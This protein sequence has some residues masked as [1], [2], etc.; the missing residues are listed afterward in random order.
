VAEKRNIPAVLQGLIQG[1]YVV[2]KDYISRVVEAAT[3][4]TSPGGEGEPK[5]PL[6]KDFD[7]SWPDPMRFVPPVANEPIRRDAKLLAPNTQRADIFYGFTFVF[8]LK[9]Q[10]DQ[11]QPVINAGSGKAVLFEKFQEGKTDPKDFVAFVK[12][13]AGEKGTGE[14]NDSSQNKGVVV[15]RLATKNVAWDTHFVQES[16]RQLNQRSLEQNE[17]LDTILMVNTGGLRKRLAEQIDLESTERPTTSNVPR[18]VT[19]QQ[20]E[21]S[22]SAVSKSEPPSQAA[23]RTKTESRF[24]GFDAFDSDED[25]EAEPDTTAASGAVTRS[26]PQIRQD[27]SMEDAQNLPSSAPSR[28]TR[29]TAVS[30]TRKRPTPEPT[31]GDILDEILPAQA[32]M[33]R[34]RLNQNS[35]SREKTPE[36]EKQPV[37]R[38]RKEREVDLL[39]EVQK[40]T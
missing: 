6:E 10:F 8:C 39:A 7:G 36:P 25:D 31:Q 21:E 37:R 33:K 1:R 13:V 29:L 27:V 5:A 40:T 2:T 22:H 30:N 16:D 11:L 3:E 18:P 35:A 19:S 4:I 12:N 15:V 24:K 20:P 38:T 17:F 28:G 26:M 14:L 23:R 32:A 9:T 34:R